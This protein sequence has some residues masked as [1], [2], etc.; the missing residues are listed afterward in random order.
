MK[1]WTIPKM[2]EGGQAW[3]IGGGSSMPRQF[4]ISEEV[5][6]NVASKQ[7]PITI[8]SD[9]LSLL[10]NEHVVGVNMA[11][12]LGDWISVSYFCD[13]QFYRIN[14][15]A[16]DR[17]PNLKATCVNHLPRHLLPG[18]GNIKRLRRDNRYGLS[19]NREVICWNFNSGCA[20]IN[21]AVHAGVKRIL[22]LGFDMMPDQEGVTHWCQGFPLYT[23]ATG[24]GVFKRF[25]RTFPS[26]AKDAKA[27][28]V[29]ILNVSPDSAIKAFP[30]V[31]LKDVA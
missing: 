28:G 10:H 18:T 30:R 23:K 16:I 9:Y 29:E 8:Y 22:L 6:G 14:K 15:E 31:S 26:I 5:I 24:P 25:L 12:M 21:F 3:I 27:M 20:A 4:G 2:W 1:N 11:F 7:D 13:S 17:F 19:N